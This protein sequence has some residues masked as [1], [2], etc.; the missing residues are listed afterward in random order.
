MSTENA[1]AG[2]PPWRQAGPLLRATRPRQWAKNLLIYL[3]FFFTLGQHDVEGFAGE[4]GLLGR[5][6]LAL[7]LFSL[8]TGATYIIN[9]LFDVERDRLH[10]RK[11]L[12]PLASGSLST[13]AAVAASA[14]LAAGGLAGSFVLDRDLGFVALAY[15]VLMLMYS[16]TLK[17]MVILDVFSIS[18][19]FVLRAA[20]GALVIDV[21]IS[22]WL[23][24]MTSLGALLIALGKRRNELSTLGDAGIEHRQVL[25][26]YTLPLVDQLVAVVA[27]A[28]AVAYTLYTFTADNL[29]DNSSMMLTV[30]FVIYGIFRYLYVVHRGN[31]GGAPEEIF[32]TDLPLMIN[33]LLWLGMASGILLAYR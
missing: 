1:A 3:A 30:P 21:P 20:A 16:A 18:G 33:N 15:L 23:Y 7:L 22:P 13:P 32:L 27:P 25:K 9:D 10:P 14:V 12:R 8:L 29:P 6:T 26:E 19:G 28:A 5:V 4:A 31:L 2:G 17:N 24:V 11:R